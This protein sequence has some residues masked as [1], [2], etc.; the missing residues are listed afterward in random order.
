MSVLLR[1]VDSL[2]RGL[3]RFLSLSLSIVS[4]MYTRDHPQPIVYSN[5]LN[6]LLISR[7]LVQNNYYDYRFPV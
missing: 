6:M 7:V 5:K 2:E 3:T 4:E 1:Q